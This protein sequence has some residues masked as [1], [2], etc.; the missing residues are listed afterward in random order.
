MDLTPRAGSYET[1]EGMKISII[2]AGH[3]GSTLGAGWA[4]HGHDIAFGVRN[5][6]KTDSATT[7]KIVSVMEAAQSSD[8]VVLAVPWN[9]VADA[10]LSAG[11]LKGKILLDATNPLLPDLSGLDTSAGSSGGETVAKLSSAPVVKIFNSTGFPNMANPDYHGQ[12]ATMLY[13]GDDV[14]AKRI[15][16]DLARQLG[17][18]PLDAGPLSNAHMLESLAL[19]WITLAIKQ[20]YGVNMAFKLMRR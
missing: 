1:G 20:G 8:V 10:L 2:G 3:V 12:S 4:K 13:C 16:A 17:F 18:D 14:N 11:D 15:A 9:G 7:A 19:L 5:P 6:K